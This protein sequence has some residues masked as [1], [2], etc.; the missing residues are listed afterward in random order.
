[1]RIGEVA[2]AVPVK[3]DPRVKPEEVAF[4]RGS[5]RFGYDD[6]FAIAR[7]YGGGWDTDLIAAGFRDH[8]GERLA[9]LRGAKL[10][11]AWRGF[12]E[13]WVTRRGR[14]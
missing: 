2:I 12:C 3:V 7:Q 10:V 14:A 13:S 11:A 4:P 6:L 8:M 9:K 5:I 1:M